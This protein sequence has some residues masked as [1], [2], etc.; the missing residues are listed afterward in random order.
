MQLLISSLAGR[1]AYFLIQ[2][3]DPCP[4]VAA[5]GGDPG[6][7]REDRHR[8]AQSSRHRQPQY[9]PLDE[10]VSSQKAQSMGVYVKP[11]RFAQSAARA[12]PADGAQFEFKR[13]CIDFSYFLSSLDHNMPPKVKLISLQ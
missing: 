3:S 6:D 8:R 1:H 2:K 4:G 5:S 13:F 11:M 12:S 10:R 9:H 7:L